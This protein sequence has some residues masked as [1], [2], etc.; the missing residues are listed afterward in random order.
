MGG[1]HMVGFAP[2]KGQSGA[3]MKE[4]HA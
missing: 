2:T 1:G 4:A 3:G